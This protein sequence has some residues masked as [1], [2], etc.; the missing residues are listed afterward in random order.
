MRLIRRYLLR[1]LLAPFLFGLG[2]LTSMLI[3][4][5]VAKR[6]GDLVGKGLGWQVIAEFFV[7]SLPFIIALTLPMAVLVAVLYAFTHLSADS[8]ITAMRASGISVGQILRPVF[9]AG[10]FTAVAA[11][12]FIDQ[13]LPRSNARLKDLQTDI[14]MKK[15]AFTLRE[16]VMNPI[17]PSAYWLRASR[18]DAGSGALREVVLYDMGMQDKR[19]VIVADS[20]G[21]AFD[22]GRLN[23]TVTLHHGRTFEYQQAEPTRLQATGFGRMVILVRD[24]ENTLQLG[25]APSIRGDR[26]MTSCEMMDRVRAG[27]RA[28]DLAVRTRE[29][30]VRR[31]LRALMRLAETRAPPPLIRDRAPPACGTWRSLERLL[32]GLIFPAPAE[33]QERLPIVPVVPQTPEPGAADTTT[34]GRTVDVMLSSITEISSADDLYFQE[35]RT[36]NTFA[37]EVHKKWAIALACLTFVLIGVALA[38]RFPR[39]GMGLVIGASLAIFSVFYIGLTV[40]ENLADHGAIPPWVGMWAPN[41]IIAGLGLW[42]LLV[43]NRETGTTRGGDLADLRESLRNFFLFRRRR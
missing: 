31:D 38:L 40:G 13:I 43:V 28:A 12:V 41:L 21:L 5:Q 9:L 29:S 17:L 14:S 23:L 4:N 15:P 3:L 1:Q 20:G 22:E 27:H 19:R 39:G 35:M 34:P 37:V 6:L 11:F 26:E 36:A 32:G 42:G 33:A 8:E 2:A 25:G 7:L 18:I 30:L 16:Q 24:V 10:L